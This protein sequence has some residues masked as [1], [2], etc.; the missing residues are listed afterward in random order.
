MIAS[1]EREAVGFELRPYQEECVRLVLA[2]YEQNKSSSEL[3]CLPT[4]TGKTVVF[5]EVIHR[6]NTQYGLN[7][8]I[9][10]H[11]DEL[12]TQAAEKYRLVK[13]DAII[14]KVG[15]G[16]HEYGAEV[17]VASIATICRPEHL[18]RLKH[19]GYGLVI[20]DEGHH[21]QADSYQR[22]YEA[23]SD[24]FHLL[25]TAT[26]DRLDKKE[27]LD[28]KKPLYSASILDMIRDKY[29]CDL[30]AVA[31]RTETDL[32][33][34]HTEMGDYKVGELE[35]AVDTPSRNKRVVEAYQEHASGRRALCFGVTVAHATHLCEA[36]QEAGVPAGMVEGNTPLEER[37]RLYRALREGTIRVLCNVQ[38]LTEGFDMPAVSCVIMARP[39]Q[40]RGL[41]TQMAGRGTRLAPGKQDCIIL[42]LTDNC[43]KH[44]L[45]PQNLKKA[46]EQPG[47]KDGESLL[48]ALAREEQEKEDALHIAKKQ[49]RRLSDSRKEDMTVDLLEKLLWIENFQTGIFT[50]EV[51]QEK[52][53]IALVPEKDGSGWYTVWARLAPSFEAQRWMGAQPLDWA[54]QAAEKKARVLLSDSKAVKLI[55]RNAPWRQMPASEKQ[56]EALAKWQRRFRLVYDPATVTKGQ[57]ADLLDPIY[58]QFKQVREAREQKGIYV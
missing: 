28:G 18:R 38:V 52:H 22:V 50:L 45:E 42:D 55:D 1:R 32:S 58:E 14:G 4:G 47:M 49:I 57:A 20:T 29:L 44:R 13:P 31:I 27:L 15:S 21:S 41:Y 51:G 25:V 23:L 43:L 33:D 3:L 46:I 24:S 12:L 39:T 37:A 48:E 17:T 56:L 2:A 40:S 8:L 54:Q 11:R 6:L 30:K 7:S 19:I 34:L 53:R 36:F 9:I 16:V 35:R 5:A 10:A 26:P